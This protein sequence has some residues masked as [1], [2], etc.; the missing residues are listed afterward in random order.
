MLVTDLNNQ[1]DIAEENDSSLKFD[2]IVDH[3]YL[4]GILELNVN[5]S[6]DSSSWMSIDKM[7]GENPGLVAEYVVSTELGKVSNVI[8]RR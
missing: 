7:K 4:S 2:R 3:R 1:F 6:D 5:Y 8:H